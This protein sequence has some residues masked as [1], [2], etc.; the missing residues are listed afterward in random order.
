MRCVLVF[1]FQLWKKEE[2]GDKQWHYNIEE[3]VG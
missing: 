3:V 2:E 1:G